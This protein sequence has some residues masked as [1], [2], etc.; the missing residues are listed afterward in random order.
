MR[1]KGS[2]SREDPILWIICTFATPG[3]FQLNF[4]MSALKLLEL[5]SGERVNNLEQLK[6]VKALDSQVVGFWRFTALF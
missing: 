3:I 2:I 6:C 5:L 1:V 4:F